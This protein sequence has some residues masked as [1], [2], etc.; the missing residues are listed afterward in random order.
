MFGVPTS[1]FLIC[2]MA[3]LGPA[4]TLAQPPPDRQAPAKASSGA[5]PP[6]PTRDPN[7]PGYVQAKELSDGAISSAKERRELYHRPH[8]QCR[9][10]N[11][12]ERRR[13]Q[14]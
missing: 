12:R 8:A 6:A 7:T 9:A 13:A 1:A 11:G 2:L 10:G 3:G 5:R 14:G 4:Q